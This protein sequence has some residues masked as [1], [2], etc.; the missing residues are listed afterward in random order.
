MCQPFR[1]HLKKDLSG[2]NCRKI[3]T[4]PQV[5]EEWAKLPKCL[6]HIPTGRRVDEAAKRFMMNPNGEE[7]V[8]VSKDV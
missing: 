2:R 1:L 4:K 7:L 5:G 8:K 3:Y 6:C